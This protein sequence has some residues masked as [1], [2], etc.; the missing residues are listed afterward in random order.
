MLGVLEKSTLLLFTILLVCFGR[1]VVK[2][3][4]YLAE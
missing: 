1:G 2:K 4:V 3:K